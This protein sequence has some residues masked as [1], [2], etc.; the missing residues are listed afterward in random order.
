[1]IKNTVIA[2][3][4]AILTTSVHG[5]IVRIIPTVSTVARLFSTKASKDPVLIHALRRLAIATS[6]N[7]LKDF[8]IYG[9][10]RQIQ[11]DE[12]EE[13]K[14]CAYSKDVMPQEFPGNTRGHCLCQRN[15]E[16]DTKKYF[17][18]VVEDQTKLKQKPAPIDD[19]PNL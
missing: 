19:I 14:Y 5:T 16:F 18:I 13:R 12:C 6:K 15:G 7:G 2:T 1:M 8:E 4:M 11:Y 9:M 17:L 10:N 3:M